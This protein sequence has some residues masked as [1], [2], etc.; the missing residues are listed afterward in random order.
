MYYLMS[1]ICIIGVNFYICM[2]ISSKKN[3]IVRMITDANNLFLIQYLISSIVF[4]AFEQFSVQRTLVLTCL[5][6]IIGCVVVYVKRKKFVIEGESQQKNNRTDMIFLC[7]LLIIC[8]PLIRVTSEDINAS[9]DL[10]AYFAHT[11][12]FSMGKSESIHEGNEIGKIS[13]AVDQET[14][15][16][17]KELTIYYQNEG[18][19][20]RYLFAL[21]TWCAIP[22]LFGKMFGFWKCMISLN[23]IYI[24]LSLNMMHLAEKI[25][26]NKYGKYLSIGVFS[27]SPLIL[28]V[29]KAGLSELVMVYLLVLSLKYLSEQKAYFDILAGICFGLIGFIHVSAFIYVPVIALFALLKSTEEKGKGFAI[30]NCV[31]ITMYLFSLWYAYRISP[32]YIERQ[33]A[34][35][36]LDGRLSYKFLFLGI[37]LIIIMFDILQICVYYKPIKIIEIIKKFLLSHFKLIVSFL[38]ILIL[39]RSI[40]YG[41]TLCFTNQ[42]A[43]PD[44]V[45]AGSWNMRNRYVNSGLQAVSYLNI[46]N[47]ARATGIIGFIAFIVLPFKHRDM[48]ETS[49][50]FYYIALYSILFFTVLQMDTPFNYYASRYFVP[51]VVPMIV[52]TLISSVESKNWCIFIIFVSIMFN[53]Y[54]WPS[55]LEG[56]PQLG[57]YAILQDS[58]SVIPKDAVVFCNEKSHD[59]NKR[60]T[61]NLRILNDNEVYNLDSY[62][63]VR[64][65][66]GK[67]KMY[68][69]SGEE[70]EKFDKI[71]IENTYSSQYSFGNGKNGNYEMGVGYYQIP[72]YIYEVD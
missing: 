30:F 50:I 62:E 45:D 58:L 7:L 44:G 41:Y 27:L 2:I 10:G 5:F 71:L 63:E 24:V 21:S 54:Y 53:R 6:S 23:W 49:K 16:L 34:R 12:V 8:I 68:I 35:M 57:Q 43:I 66:F 65:Y 3:S 69:I 22:A 13:E 18:E 33:Y 48:G 56:A 70:L 17:Q 72:L 59:V 38:F 26:K 64:K 61:S 55:F 46:V 14:K 67:E 19:D 11:A 60:L 51:F 32:V 4:I 9:T 1:V 40:Y 20:N 28:Y 52:L 39:I 42:F 36:T 15:E 37:T 29:G 25:S 31:Q 47:I